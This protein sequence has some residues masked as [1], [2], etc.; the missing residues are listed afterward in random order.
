[1]KVHRPEL[2]DVFRT[3]QDD[4]LARWNSVFVAATQESA[5]RHS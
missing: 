5:S 4:F 2:A 1:M 3:H